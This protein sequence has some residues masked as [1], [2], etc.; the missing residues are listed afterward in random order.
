ML[1]IEQIDCDVQTTFA[2]RVKREVCTYMLQDS[3]LRSHASQSTQKVSIRNHHAMSEHPRR[4][5]RVI[6]WTIV[7]NYFRSQTDADYRQ[8]GEGQVEPRKARSGHTGGREPPEVPVAK[9]LFAILRVKDMERAAPDP[10]GDPNEKI[11]QSCVIF[12]GPPIEESEI[13][14]EIKNDVLG[15]LSRKIFSRQR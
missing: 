9:R 12:D 8:L 3:A 1:L 6:S 13:K 15:R 4:W 2:S 10:N 11:R 7:T 14:T 5:G